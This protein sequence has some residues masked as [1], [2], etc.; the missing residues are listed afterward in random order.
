M[1]LLQLLHQEPLAGDLVVARHPDSFSQYKRRLSE[2][3]NGNR[4]H[5]SVKFTSLKYGGAE[6]WDGLCYIVMMRRDVGPGQTYPAP[7]TSSGQA[8][9]G[10]PPRTCDVNYE[11]GKRVVSAQAG[12]PQR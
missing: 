1:G 12:R 8:P 5:V 11:P 9:R 3:Q 4:Q 7:S 6:L 2:I 10:S